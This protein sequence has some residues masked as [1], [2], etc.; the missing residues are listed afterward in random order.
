MTRLD[1]INSCLND[2]LEITNI[3]ILLVRVNFLYRQSYLG[4]LLV[5]V[6]YH[7]Y[8]SFSWGTKLIFSN[9]ESIL[10][11]IKIILPSDIRR[12]RKR[13][14]M[15]IKAYEKSVHAKKAAKSQ[16]KINF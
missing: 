11:I 7:K 16:G 2:K 4:N 6:E 9:I 12:S 3:D 15:N 13:T 10:I 5:P 8:S 1:T 14:D